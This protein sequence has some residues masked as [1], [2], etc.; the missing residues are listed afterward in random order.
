MSE[1]FEAYADLQTTSVGGFEATAPEDEFFHSVYISGQNRNLPTGETEIAGNL[2]IRGIQYNLQ[3]VNMII[4]HVKDMNVK[5]VKISGKDAIG[6][7]SY[8]DSKPFKGSK[9]MDDGSPR[10]CPENA[11]ERSLNEFCAPCRNHIIIAGIYC[12][13]D[14][15]PVLKK[16]EDGKP[17]PIFIFIRGKGTKYGNVSNYLNDCYQ[18]DLDPFFEPVTEK[19]KEF[20]KQV[21]NNKR[22]VTKITIGE[23]SS[24][25]GPKKVFVLEA[26]KKLD[27]KVTKDILS[28]AQKTLPKFNEKFDWSKGAKTKQTDS[29]LMTVDEK[30]NQKSEEVEEPESDSFSFE[31]IKFNV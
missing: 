8:K 3:E 28:V 16:D 15:S 10:Y 19:S 23:A 4:T 5:N 17:S 27:K 31:D 7:F 22:F 9:P 11:T 20:E 29:G 1:N 24:N 26:G 25:Y 2:Q 30:T 12:K 13:P 14:G 6:C 21:V 18:M